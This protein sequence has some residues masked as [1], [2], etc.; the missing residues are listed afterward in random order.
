MQKG[1]SADHLPL[2]HCTLGPIPPLHVGVGE[3]ACYITLAYLLAM[4]GPSHLE[5]QPRGKGKHFGSH[6]N[7]ASH[8]GS[9]E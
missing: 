1:L 9:S 5:G 3:E 8:G 7:L 4:V 2:G 6:Q